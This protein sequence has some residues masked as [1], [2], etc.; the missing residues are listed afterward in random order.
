MKPAPVLAFGVRTGEVPEAPAL[1]IDPKPQVRVSH[2]PQRARRAMFEKLDYGAV[3][4]LGPICRDTNHVPTQVDALRRRLCRQ[5]PPIDPGLLAEFKEFVR[6]WLN[7]NLSPL[8]PSQVLTFD[9]WLESAPYSQARK[10]ELRKVW[11]EQSGGLPPMRKARRVNAFIKTE[12]Y[13][14]SAAGDF[15][16]ARWI[17]SRS[18]NAKVVLGPWMKSIERVVYEDPHFIKHVPVCERWKRVS[19]LR[20][21]GRRYIITDYTA[22]EASFAS[23]FMSACECQLYS[24]MLQNVQGAGQYVERVLTGV[25]NI[26]TRAGVS[27]DLVG[28]RM[29]GDMNTSLG[30]GFSN[31]MLMLFFCQ[32]LG[33]DVQGFVEGD[34]GVFA[35]SGELPTPA[36][37]TRLGFDIKLQVVDDPTYGGFCGVVAADGGSIRDPV[38]F[39]SGFAW[40]SIV[41]AG[42]DTKLQLLRAKAL[43][44]LYENPSCPLITAI[45]TRALDLTEGVE[46]RFIW[47]GYHVPP[48]VDRPAPCPITPSTRDLYFRLY[49]LTPSAQ[50]ECE[51][52]IA[53]GEA[54]SFLG[55]LL[56]HHFNHS[57][58]WN[59]YI[60]AKTP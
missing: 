12:A 48:P 47:D 6:V 30:N 15:K 52:R 57:L 56:R 33:S 26:R 58:Y 27:V 13:D 54:L 50:I 23:P 34:D 43:S 19:S 3:P 28:R 2:K 41:G 53:A 44:A 5:L 20:G 38:R 31:L 17:C 7:S 10:A 8:R 42:Q 24:Y 16:P 32:K 45:A 35:I 18:D 46:P 59:W 60:G 1:P 29:S 37:F 40:T 22:F 55:P 39:L 25:N 21:G 4:N 11:L 51:R 9:E 36:M 14:L 49:G